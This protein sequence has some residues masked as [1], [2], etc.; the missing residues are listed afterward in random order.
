MI[1][2]FA[3]PTMCSFIR[4]TWYKVEGAWRMKAIQSDSFRSRAR[5][6][7]FYRG[8]GTRTSTT[9][10]EVTAALLLKELRRLI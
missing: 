10:K 1:L 2:R 3:V 5:E 8:R 7:E 9:T 4:A 6:S